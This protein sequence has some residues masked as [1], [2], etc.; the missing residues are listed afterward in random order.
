LRFSLDNLSLMTDD[1]HRLSRLRPRFV[2]GHGKNAEIL[3]R[4]DPAVANFGSSLGT[5]A[6][7]NRA[8]L[9]ISLKPLA[10]RGGLSAR[11]VANRSR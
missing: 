6:L 2:P 4:A 1:R 11:A 5:T 7:V 8:S 9:F 3:T 10:E